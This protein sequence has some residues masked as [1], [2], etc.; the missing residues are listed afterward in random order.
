LE[1]EG[2]VVAILRDGQPVERAQAGESVAIVLGE[3]A[4][5]VEAGGQV[6]D[7][8]T[9]VSATEPRWEFAVEDTGRGIGAEELPRIFDG[10][11][12]VQST[13]ASQGVGLGLTIVKKYLEL[14]KG[15]IQV[16]SEIGKGSVFTVTLP[17]S[18][19]A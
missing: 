17:Y 18:L 13:A 2:P 9:I 5:Y 11:H 8:G 3:T 7:I 14:I 12:Q 10:F 1:V 15:T 4:F 6:S 16:K 19:E